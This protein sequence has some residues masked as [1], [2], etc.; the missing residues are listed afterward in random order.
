MKA[1][2]QGAATPGIWLYQPQP[3]ALSQTVSAAAARCGAAFHTFGPEAA[4]LTVGALVSGGMTGKAYTEALPAEPVI[5][6]D[7]L[8]KKG[9]DQFLAALRSQCAADGQPPVALKAVV[10]PTNRSW[11]FAALAAELAKEHALMHKNK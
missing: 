4:G 6:M 8:D 11:Q 2:V 3:G 7:G 10:T 9:L 5:L 1:R